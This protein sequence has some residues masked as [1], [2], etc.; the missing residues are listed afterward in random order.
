MKLLKAK[1]GD[2]SFIHDATQDWVAR[3]SALARLAA[4]R[5][6]RALPAVLESGDVRVSCPDA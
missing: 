5:A 2:E 6:G 3:S 4:D 1:P